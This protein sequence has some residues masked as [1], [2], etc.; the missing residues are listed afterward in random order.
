VL[1]E[2]ASNEGGGGALLPLVRRPGANLVLGLRWRLVDNGWVGSADPAGVWP[3]AAG[4]GGGGS[5]AVGGALGR[6]VGLGDFLL[7]PPPSS[8]CRRPNLAGGRCKAASSGRASGWIRRRRSAEAEAE[9]G[10]GACGG[11]LEGQMASVATPSPLPVAMVARWPRL[12]AMR[13]AVV[14]MRRAEAR[15]GQPG[16][17][18]VLGCSPLLPPLLTEFLLRMAAWWPNLPAVVASAHARWLRRRCGG[19][20]RGWRRR[21]S[22]GATDVFMCGG[23][24]ATC[25]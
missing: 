3:E 4:S 14:A 25:A 17:P 15:E 21:W 9:A 7:T 1:L 8:W 16:R 5:A 11:G 10:G 2:G 20:L 6:P 13:R 24:G 12:A 22:S 19:R 18:S 23:D